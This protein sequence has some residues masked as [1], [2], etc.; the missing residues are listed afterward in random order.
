MPGIFFERERV[1]GARL[2]LPCAGG[3]CN[4]GAETTTP[5]APSL[6]LWRALH[7]QQQHHQKQQPITLLLLLLLRYRPTMS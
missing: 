5:R 1:A 6:R 7:R 3:G 2:L 4:I